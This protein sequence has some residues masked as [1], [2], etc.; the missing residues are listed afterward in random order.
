MVLQSLASVDKTLWDVEPPRPGVHEE[1]VEVLD[2]AEEGVIGSFVYQKPDNRKARLTTQINLIMSDALRDMT[3]AALDSYGTF[4]LEHAKHDTHVEDAEVP[5]YQPL[6]VL[7]V[8]SAGQGEL[9]YS[10]ASQQ[11]VD[12]PLRLLDEALGAL[13]SLQTADIF[14]ISLTEVRE[15]CPFTLT[16]TRTRTR[17][18]TLISTLTLTPTLTTY[19]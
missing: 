3:L 13:G 1:I 2:Q 11:F 6:F 18:L 9:F 14:D 16:R 12:D 7:E 19:P 5:P 17:T 10:T 4:L 8:I 15:L